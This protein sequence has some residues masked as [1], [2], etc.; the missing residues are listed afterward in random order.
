MPRTRRVRIR[1]G[2]ELG[3][4]GPIVFIGGPCVIESEKTLLETCGRLA[5]ICGELGIGFVFKTSYDKANRTSV[6]SYRGPGLR[7]G[8]RAVEKV[9]KKFGVPALLDVHKE[10][11][12][13]PAA[14]VAEILQIPAFLCRQTDLIQ[15]AAR[16]RRV[17]NIKKGQ[18]LS[19]SDARYAA[20]KV[21]SAGNPNVTLT[22]RGA[23]FGYGNL[24]VDMRSLQII[25]EFGIPAIFDAT[26]S[27]QM[28]GAG[29]K[30]AGDRRFVPALSRAAVAAGIDGLFMEVHPN[31]ARAKSDAANQMPLASV[32]GLLRDLIEIDRVVKSK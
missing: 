22:E 2:L 6:R 10:S 15:A 7:A 13:G 32:R 20:E 28:P 31:P 12:C 8:L 14:E 26:H 23:S 17:V 25:R 9:K 29:G 30:T 27:V 18:F 19:P 11:E 4:G 24:V 3:G 16:T 1:P 5:E 21:T